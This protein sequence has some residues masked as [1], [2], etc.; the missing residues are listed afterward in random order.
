MPAAVQARL[1]EVDGAPPPQPGYGDEKEAGAI[2]KRVGAAQFVVESTSSREQQR[3]PPAPFTTSTLQQEANN[4]LGLSEC[5]GGAGLGRAARGGRALR[6]GAHRTLG[7]ADRPLT[8][9]A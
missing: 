2:A 6:D 7:S 3:Q 9:Q 4:R 1:T 5:E 8:P